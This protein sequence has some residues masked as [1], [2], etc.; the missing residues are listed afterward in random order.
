MDAAADATKGQLR[1]RRTAAQYATGHGSL[2]LNIY[3]L[4][5]I[6]VVV[7]R[8]DGDTAMNTLENR[9]KGERMTFILS[10][11]HIGLLGVWSGL[12]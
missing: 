9:K 3:G 11:V 2:L 12:V 10:V 4:V 1:G 5:V 7:T 6:I 8:G